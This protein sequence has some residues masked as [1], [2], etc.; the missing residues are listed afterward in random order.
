MRE[1]SPSAPQPP[2]PFPG[3]P[4]RATLNGKTSNVTKSPALYIKGALT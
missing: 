4:G 3:V 1:E 2:A